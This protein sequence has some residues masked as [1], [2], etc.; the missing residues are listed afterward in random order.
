GSISYSGGSINPGT[1]PGRIDGTAASGGSSVSY[2][3]QKKTTGGYT[4][5]SGATGRNY[6]SGSLTRTTTFKRIATT[7][8]G[9]S[10]TSNE[11]T[12]AVNLKPGSIASGSETICRGSNP[13]VINST[14]GASGGVGNYQYQWQVFSE[15]QQPTLEG[16]GSVLE[17]GWHDLPGE[18]GLTFD[19]PVLNM[20]MIYRRKVTSGNQIAYTSPKSY[21]VS[22]PLTA[23][24]ISY[25]G[26]SVNAE[27]NPP[28]I[29]GT[30]VSGGISPVYQWQSKV[31]TATSFSNISGAT[32]KNYD[33]P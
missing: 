10:A 14:A 15:L 6:Q 27:G 32:G 16:G 17:D 3:W 18:T 11:V 9:S 24:S 12:I 5:I 25:S 19:P 30:T 4:N 1:A 8:C 26:G 22:A 21:T 33:P 28:S 31:G 20:D 29:T 7:N 2:Q 13:G 23:G